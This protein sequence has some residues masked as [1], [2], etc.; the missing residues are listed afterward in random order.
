MET[1]ML[2]G[3]YLYKEKDYEDMN[4]MVIDWS[5]NG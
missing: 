3:W 5:S 4:R 2:C 1:F